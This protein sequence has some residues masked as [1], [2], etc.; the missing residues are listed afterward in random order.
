M[1]RK[2]LQ[3]ESKT[4]LVGFLLALSTFTVV[5][6][7]QAISQSPD[8]LPVVTTTNIEY[9]LSRLTNIM[10]LRADN[11]KTEGNNINLPKNWV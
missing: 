11:L 3:I 1:R 5:Q 4:S 8:S 2:T 10:K 7:A 6:E 9:R